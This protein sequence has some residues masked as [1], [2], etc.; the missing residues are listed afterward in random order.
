MKIDRRLTLLGVMLI[1]LSMTLATQYATTKITF[2]YGIVHPSNADIR[3]IGSDNSSDDIKVL[4]VSNNATTSQYLTISLGDWSPNSIKNYSAAFGIVNEE[5]FAINIT[6][7]NISGTGA[8]YVSV[9]LHG[10]RSKEINDEISSAKV[11]VVNG[12]TDVLG[13]S[14]NCAWKLAAGNDNYVNMNGTSV[15]TPWDENAHVRYNSTTNV[16]AINGSRDFVWV[17]VS[18]NLPSNADTSTTPTGQIWIHFK[19]NTNI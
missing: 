3:F 6:H 19:A 4:R 12:G 10:N 8:S 7:V 2:S 18:I 14:S 5:K 16:Y 17:Q 15:L 13:S 9:W 11:R 1:V